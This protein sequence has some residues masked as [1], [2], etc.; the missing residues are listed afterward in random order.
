MEFLYSLF[1][2]IQSWFLPYL[3]DELGELT[4]RQVR[5]VRAV[6]LL[7]PL[8]FIDKY[9]WAGIGRRPSGRLCLLKTLF[10]SF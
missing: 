3:E 1:N 4:T 5:F 2:S 6:E 7:N 9:N 8:E 10:N